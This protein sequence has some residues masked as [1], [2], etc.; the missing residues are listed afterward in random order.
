MSDARKLEGNLHR[1]YTHDPFL[2]AAIPEGFSHIT[3]P[4]FTL[5]HCHW[6]AKV[7]QDS[8]A[9]VN[10][11][12]ASLW[13]LLTLRRAWLGILK[14]AELSASIQKLKRKGLHSGVHV[15]A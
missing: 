1:L 9:H 14:A 3:Q 7:F 12:A 2:L 11:N 8:W 10:I 15:L 6:I 4:G 5:R 13:C